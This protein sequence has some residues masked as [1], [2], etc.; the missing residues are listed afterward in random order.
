[1]S[2]SVMATTALLKAGYFK[3]GAVLVS[4]AD[5]GSESC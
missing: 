2:K 5:K 3:G 1:M 4:S